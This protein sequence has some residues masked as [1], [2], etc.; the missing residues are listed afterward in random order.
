MIGEFLELQIT[1]WI[2]EKNYCH[3]ICQYVLYLQQ[4]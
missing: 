2:W 1:I 3:C 4:C